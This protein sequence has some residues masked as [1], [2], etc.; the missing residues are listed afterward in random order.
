MP[1]HRYAFPNHNSPLD[2]SPMSFKS[3]PVEPPMPATMTPSPPFPSPTGEP[4]LSRSLPPLEPQH[5]AIPSYLTNQRRGSITDPSLH[6]SVPKPEIPRQYSQTDINFASNA[7]ISPPNERRGSFVMDNYPA[8]PSSSL[9]RPPSVKSEHSFPLMDSRNKTLPSI[10]ASASP[11]RDGFPGP[12]MNP[13]F[14]AQF[15]QRRHS[16][17][18]GEVVSPATK[19]KSSLGASVLSNSISAEDY[20][21]KR[22]DSMT[23]PISRLSLYDR[24]SSYS[25]PSSPPA[26][27]SPFASSSSPMPKLNVH[28][29][30]NSLQAHADATGLHHPYGESSSELPPPNN[31]SHLQDQT[32]T[33]VAYPPFNHRVS[34][35]VHEDVNGAPILAR[36]ASMP[37]MSL[38]SRFSDHSQQEATPMDV[39]RY[40]SHGYATHNH[41]YHPYAYEYSG[42]IPTTPTIKDTPYSRSPELRISHKLAERKRR[43]EMKDLFDEL[44]DSLP[45]DKSLKTSKWEILSKGM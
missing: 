22:R 30:D 12:L 36:R 43:K 6:L 45:V 18:V 20:A 2:S 25:A 39:D 4:F 31:M 37:Q 3:A 27:P 24:R 42:Y 16:I 13:A 11:I 14:Q 38:T 8:S 35:I 28:E 29:V 10:S 33:Q 7:P 44:R 23:D 9:S 32:D 21:G 34:Q 1:E 5:S 40:R 17:A 15:A 19:R 41:A 26:Q